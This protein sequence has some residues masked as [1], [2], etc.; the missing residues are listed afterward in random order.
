MS[1]QL[2]RWV[3]AS[4]PEGAPSAGNFR[5]ESGSLRKTAEGEVLVRVLA[6]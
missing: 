2:R 6:G 4:R 1:K 5:M 3:L